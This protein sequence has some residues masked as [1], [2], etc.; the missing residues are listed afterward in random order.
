M[1]PCN[2]DAYGAVLALPTVAQGQEDGGPNEVVANECIPSQRICH[3]TYVKFLLVFGRAGP[4]ERAAGLVLGPV[5]ADRGR[6]PGE[7]VDVGGVPRRPALGGLEREV[8]EVPM[9]AQH[10][11]SIQSVVFVFFPEIIC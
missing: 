3:P 2:S 9:K 6:I 7:R 8:P 10:R 5:L 1:S 11:T 4:V